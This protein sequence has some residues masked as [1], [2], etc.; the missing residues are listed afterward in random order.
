MTDKKNLKNIVSL[1]ELKKSPG[2]PSDEVM[3]KGPAVV[4]ECVQEIP[5]DPCEDVCKK[6][7]IV[8]G[9][10]ITNL[11]KLVNVENCTNCGQCVLACPGLA[12]FIVDKTYSK[13]R[14][15]I[16]IP[17][18]LI[19]LPEV[20]EKVIGLDRS[21]NEVCDAEIIKVQT[22]KKFNN[23]SLV[24]LAVPKK[25]TEEVRFFKRKLDR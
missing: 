17:Y 14:T 7:V 15:L 21:G 24:K 4:I 8:V 6:K 11:P 13:D 22:N 25:Y 10:P 9:K 16:T 12:I 23:T 18:E 3:N 2:Y 5:C 1:E 19:P 20:G